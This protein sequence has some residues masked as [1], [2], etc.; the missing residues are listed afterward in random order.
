[1]KKY[2]CEISCG[3]GIDG[4]IIDSIPPGDLFEIFAVKDKY[5]D[6]ALHIAA[7]FGEEKI[8]KYILNSKK[9]KTASRLKLESWRIGLLK[10]V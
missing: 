10:F 1:L 5:G 3:A 7:Y 9:A 6:T 8:V 2:F 4:K